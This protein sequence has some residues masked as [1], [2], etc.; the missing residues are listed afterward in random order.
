[1]GFYTS[2]RKSNLPGSE[3]HPGIKCVNTHY[4]I[5]SY[6]IIYNVMSDPNYNQPNWNP[7][8]LLFFKPRGPPRRLY[9]CSPRRLRV[10][11]A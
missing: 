5:S 11:F 7:L 4:I 10:D 9:L 3:G 2:A 6:I 8:E 1:M